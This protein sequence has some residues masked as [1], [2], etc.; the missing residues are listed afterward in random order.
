MIENW[1]ERIALI[2]LLPA[3]WDGYGAPRIEERALFL[4]RS[5]AEVITAH[6]PQVVAGGSGS[7]QLEWHQNGLDVELCVSPDGKSVS[8]YIGDSEGEITEC[9]TCDRATSFESP[10]AGIV[11]PRSGRGA[12]TVHP[13]CP[14][15]CGATYVRLDEHICK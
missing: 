11:S 7:V 15:G 13:V 10:N 3:N 8:A 9:D 4:A 6:P 1:Q 14:N 5:L 12:P 2:G